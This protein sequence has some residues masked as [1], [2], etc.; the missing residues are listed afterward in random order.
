MFWS[1]FRAYTLIPVFI[2]II[3]SSYLISYLLKDKDDKVRML[4]IK[5]VTI[6][7]LVLEVIK[8]TL[9]IILRGYDLY[10]IPLHFCSLFL[11]F[12]PIASFYNGKHKDVFRTLGAV[13]STCL[14]L[15]MSI[16]PLLIYPDGDIY[17]IK[18]FLGGNLERFFQFHSVVF[19]NIALYPFFF[20]A[21]NKVL[22]HDKKKDIKAIIIAFVIYSVIA[23]TLANLIDTNFN[24]FKSCNADFLE[25]VRVA[26]VDKIGV[27]GQVIY[28]LM[29]GVGTVIVPLLAY[30]ILKL[31]E[32]LSE[33]V[34]TG[35]N[36]SFVMACLVSLGLLITIFNVG[37]G[38][39]ICSIFTVIEIS[40]SIPTLINA[41][42]EK[43]K[44]YI[45]FASLFTLIGMVA[46]IVEFIK[47]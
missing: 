29:I 45:L 39:I 17:G 28:V 36:V 41:I 31:F 38:M 32:K 2:F 43:N 27:F 19:H 11:Y 8:Q 1:Q 23:G 12:L 7:L 33:N 21:F 9:S 37:L 47:L 20:F 6:I 10:H 4:P 35:L 24:N 26:M 40:A 13:I 15:F 44:K 34:N 18:E 46:V 16:Y 25:N 3:L 30:L 22:N 5:I 42:R 14:F